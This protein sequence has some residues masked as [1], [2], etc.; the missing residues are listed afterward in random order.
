MS[1]LPC[2]FLFACFSLFAHSVAY[3]NSQRRAESFG[4]PKEKSW[5]V[6]GKFFGK[7]LC[8]V[9]W[10]VVGGLMARQPEYVYEFGPFRLDAAERLL[11]RDGEAVSLSPRAFDLL[12]TLVE[13]YGRLLEKEE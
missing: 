10:S 6:F 13:R 5:K 3:H 2:F 11:S 1:Q 9:L 12:L 4:D 7:I 8:W